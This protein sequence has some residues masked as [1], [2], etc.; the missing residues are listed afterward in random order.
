MRRIFLDG[1]VF[2]LSNQMGCDF[3]GG[4]TTLSAKMVSC[5]ILYGTKTNP[6]DENGN[7]IASCQHDAGAALCK[8][9][10]EKVLPILKEGLKH[11]K[12]RAVEFSNFGQG[13]DLPFLSIKK[14]DDTG[15]DQ[16]DIA[17]IKKLLEEVIV[18][19]NEEVD[20][21]EKSATEKKAKPTLFRPAATNENTHPYHTRSKGLAPLGSS[22][23]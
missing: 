9:M 20:A 23:K 13:N 16:A 10:Q 5:S 19:N 6:Q 22:S 7:S 21:K 3:V 14:I 12:F 11:S 2:A 1:E 4:E 18:A 8:D 15:F 17:G